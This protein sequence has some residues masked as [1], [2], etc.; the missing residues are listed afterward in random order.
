MKTRTNRKAVYAHRKQVREAEL[1]LEALRLFAEAAEGGDP[2]MA[3]VTIAT[4]VRLR[5]RDGLIRKHNENEVHLHRHH[6]PTEKG[7]ALL[8]GIL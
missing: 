7:W 5:D 3:H 1:D 8:K 6:V 4:V 2:Y